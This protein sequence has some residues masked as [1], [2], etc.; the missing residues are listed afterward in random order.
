MAGNNL[1]GNNFAGN[2]LAG[3]KCT[4]AGNKKISGNIKKILAD[5]CQRDTG[6]V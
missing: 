5:F 1:A 6:M 2:N 4:H 3:N